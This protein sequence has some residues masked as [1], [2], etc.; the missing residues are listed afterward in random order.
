MEHKVET[1]KRSLNSENQIDTFKKPKPV[2][3]KSKILFNEVLKRCRRMS[4]K[5]VK[6]SV[7]S[8]KNRTVNGNGLCWEVIVSTSLVVVLDN[9]REFIGYGSVQIKM[10]SNVGTIIN[11]AFSLSCKNAEEDAFKKIHSLLDPLESFVP[12]SSSSSSTFNNNHS[13]LYI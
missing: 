11:H 4:F 7:L 13:T 9:T 2:L 12:S 3:S 6:H 5:D 8:L 10:L 1:K